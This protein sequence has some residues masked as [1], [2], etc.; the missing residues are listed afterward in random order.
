MVVQAGSYCMTI[1][2]NDDSAAHKNKRMLGG[3]GG[4]SS[5]VWKRWFISMGRFSFHG[6][7]LSVSYARKRGHVRKQVWKNSARPCLGD[8][9]PSPWQKWRWGR[10]TNSIPRQGMLSRFRCGNPGDLGS[11]GVGPYFRR[12]KAQRI[13]RRIHVRNPADAHFIEFLRMI[14]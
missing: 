14:E 13:M 4:D 5:I 3:S 12:S 9:S 8:A 11:S 10:T 1:G 2:I 7:V 6:S